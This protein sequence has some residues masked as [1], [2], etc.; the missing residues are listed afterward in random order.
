ML[1]WQFAC[2]NGQERK[3]QLSIRKMH[4]LHSD[5]CNVNDE[6]QGACAKRRI[7]RCTSGMTMVVACQRR[8]RAIAPA[9]ICM[10]TP[11]THPAMIMAVQAMCGSWRSTITPTDA[12][13]E[14]AARKVPTA[15]NNSAVSIFPAVLPFEDG[16]FV[17]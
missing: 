10:A 7:L 4:S 13:A 11:T 8:V 3:A 17:G 5:M 9:M 6:L 2:S 1:F 15:L 16:S 14:N 12:N